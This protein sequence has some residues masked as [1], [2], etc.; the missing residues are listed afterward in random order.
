MPI[1]WSADAL[2]LIRGQ[3][4]QPAAKLRDLLPGSYVLVV[5]AP[6]E[7]SPAADPGLP[8]WQT[9]DGRTFTVLH[10]TV[11]AVSTQRIG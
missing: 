1:E 7:P 6:D 3:R 4:P 2:A 11:D 8:Q 9:E 5:A 10:Q